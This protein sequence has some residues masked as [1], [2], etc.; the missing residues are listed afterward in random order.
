MER[1]EVI[2]HTPNSQKLFFQVMG[3]RLESYRPLGLFWA[4]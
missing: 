2:S 3:D 4:I 1:V